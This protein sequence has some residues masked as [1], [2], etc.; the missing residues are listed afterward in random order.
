MKPFTEME[1]KHFGEFLA[2]ARNLAV[3]RTSVEQT[4]EAGK[5]LCLCLFDKV[6]MLFDL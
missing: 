4:M 3:D 1:R 6:S 5:S 2:G